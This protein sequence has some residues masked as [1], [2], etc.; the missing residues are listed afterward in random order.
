MVKM[1]YMKIKR[2]AIAMIELIFAI[3][4]MGIILM[5]APML[6]STASKGGYVAIQQEAIN[7]AASQLN[8]ILGYHWD[9]N[10]A[11][12]RYL[13]HILIATGGDAE[14]NEYDNTARRLGTP[15]ESYRTFVRA[16]GVRSNTS[17]L[18]KDTN[19]TQDDEFDDMDDFTGTT[20]SLVLVPEGTLVTDYIETTTIDI[21]RTVSYISDDTAYNASNMTYNYDPLTPS[22][23]TNI[24]SI[25]VTL[26]SSSGLD[27][28]EKEITLHAFS[29]NIGGYKLEEMDTN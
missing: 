1:Y 19:E 25:T 18:G 22:N 11:D 8:M 13:D 9:E 27:E 7:E 24:K 17:T 5:S 2:P 20:T 6:I 3:V 15:P 26:S 14:L 12:E 28:L 10:D 29:C 21:S 4:I 23:N 16:D